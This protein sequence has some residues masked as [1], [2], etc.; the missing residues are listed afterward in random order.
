MAQK[1][2]QATSNVNSFSFQDKVSIARRILL[3]SRNVYT[4]LRSLFQNYTN[5]TYK[6]NSLPTV[7]AVA[8]FLKTHTSC[9]G[10]CWTKRK[11]LRVSFIN[12]MVI[13]TWKTYSWQHLMT[14]YMLLVKECI[15][16]ADRDSQLTL[17]DSDTVRDDETTRYDVKWLKMTSECAIKGIR[18]VSGVQVNN[19]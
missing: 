8:D 6:R 19:G 12:C 3:K 14:V 5:K 17:Q 2:Q 15:M 16:K 10:L 11:S 1:Y 18:R 4:E 13:R 7:I 9:A